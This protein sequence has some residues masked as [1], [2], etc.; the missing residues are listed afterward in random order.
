MTVEEYEQL[1]CKEVKG[2]YLKLYRA[3]LAF[4]PSTVS[5]GARALP[6]DQ[7]FLGLWLGDGTASC[8][9]IS[10]SD[11]EIAVWLQSYVDRL[12]SSRPPLDK[13]YS[14]KKLATPAGKV[15]ANG[16]VGNGDVFEYRISTRKVGPGP[17]PVRDGLRELGLLGDK[18]GGIPFAYMAADEDTRLA[19]I[20]GLIDSD[21]CYIK[22]HNENRFSQMTEGH[23]QIVYDLKKLAHSCGISVTGVDIQM[24]RN[25]ITA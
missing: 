25:R 17:N 7:Y 24:T 13:L 4:D 14:V 3:P 18:S 9:G 2:N 19:V 20:A 10:T 22:S 21:G 6:V 23:K 5:A 1:C 16:Y 15:M 11:R 12:N 8:A